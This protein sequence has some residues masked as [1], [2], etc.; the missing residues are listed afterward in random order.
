MTENVSLA[1][2]VPL[3]DNKLEL[4]GVV[5]RLRCDRTAPHSDREL[6]HEVD[7]IRSEIHRTTGSSSETWSDAGGTAPPEGVIHRKLPE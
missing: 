2:A 7:P 1:M 5:F 4:E 3:F 6:C